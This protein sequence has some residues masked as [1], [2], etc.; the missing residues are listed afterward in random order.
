[1]RAIRDVIHER[2][3]LLNGEEVLY[4]ALAQLLE[5]GAAAMRSHPQAGICHAGGC[6]K[7]TKARERYCRTHD[8]GGP[9]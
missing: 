7:T 3:P 1:M 2:T 4:G 5:A 9:A 6:T 8:V